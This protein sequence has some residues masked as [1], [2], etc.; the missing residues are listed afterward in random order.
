M[1]LIMRRFSF[2]RFTRWCFFVLLIEATCLAIDC[3]AVTLTWDSNGSTTPNPSDG[4]GNWNG[5]GR[6][7]NGSAN[8]NWA[9]ANDAVFGTGAGVVGTY[10]VTNN[11]ALVQPSSVT[12]TNPGSYTITSD[13]VN[14][15]QLAWTAPSGGVG[16]VSR[17]LWV[18]ANVTTRIDV[19]WRDASGS[20]IFLGSNSVLTF[21]QG[22][23]G[24]S[25]SVIFKGSGAAVSTVNAING[26]WGGPNGSQL[27]ATMDIAGAT[28]NISNSAIINAGT[29]FDIGR[30]VTGAP[31]SDGIVNVGNG[32]QFNANV[33]SAADPNANLQLS[34]G[35]PAVLN[36]LSGGVV[37]TR[38]AGSSG[39]VLLIPDSGS[40]ATLNMMGGTL[41]VGTGAG[42]TPGVSSPSLSLIALM[43]GSMTY[44]SSASAI[45]NLFSGTVTARGIQIGSTNGTF[46]SNPTNQINITGGILYLDTLNISLPKSTGT[47]FALNLSGGTVAATADWSPACTAPIN[48][49]NIN[50]DI[51]FQAADAVGNPFDMAIAAALSGIGGFLKTG[52]GTL[53]L[54]GTNTY[55][56][57][58]AINGGTIL[59]NA[60]GS[61]T[62]S[63][64]FSVTN[65]GM[66]TLLNTAAANKADRINNSVPITMDGGAFAFINDGSTASFSE[67]AG[68]LIIHSGVNVV[69]VFPA[70]NGQTSTLL[71]SSITN[72]GGSVDF[73][74]GSAGTS[75]NKVF[76]TAPPVLGSWITVNGSPAAYNSTNGLYEAATF[77]D[78]SA[79][80]STISNAPAANVRINSTGSGGNIQLDLNATVINSLQQNTTT[81]AIVD[82]ASKTFRV[83][84][85][86]VNAG[87]Q[88]L[89]IGAAPGAGVLTAGSVG[90]NLTLI[91][92]SSF[93]PGLVINASLRDNIFP[94]SL[95]V[96]G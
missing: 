12:F 41:N 18:G 70:T 95:T 33:T 92:N 11:S 43:P 10:L 29:R 6:W 69:T 73:Q 96:L 28:L 14:A 34:R 50:G 57:T 82:T 86:A 68:A 89:S 60:G 4:S 22:T 8:Q 81:A 39:R 23:S 75:Q 30:P 67:T 26:T 13:G 9:D 62:T 35:G 79:L 91:N 66:L 64:G 16:S 31:G 76:F 87:S 88:S 80:G 17:G 25:G 2:G 44:G 84:Q 83:N 15:G 5:T 71:F 61:I 94:S 56:G 77:T 46:T 27:T 7:W 37:S 65:D 1:P 54:T 32:S 48:L 42:G 19:P 74:M 52:G 40:Q 55:A 45:F 53:T 36:I 93:L 24:N 72:Y 90:G 78:I 58:T 63:S 85:I 3:E 47:K 38:S 20:D 21:S 49:T 59:L 51:T